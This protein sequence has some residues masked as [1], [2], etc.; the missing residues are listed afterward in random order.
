MSLDIVLCNNLKQ[1]QSQYELSEC[2]SI[3]CHLETEKETRISFSLHHIHVWYIM[4]AMNMIFSVKLEILL[5]FYWRFINMQHLL[6]WSIYSTDF[7]STTISIFLLIIKDLIFT[8]YIFPSWNNWQ[9][10]ICYV[11]TF[12]I[13]MRFLYF[14]PRAPLPPPLLLDPPSVSA[15]VHP[16]SVLHYQNQKARNAK[17]YSLK[18]L[19][20]TVSAISVYF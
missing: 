10:L 18:D 9:I 11:I 20:F 19:L 2:P 4:L 16:P 13:S 7:N 6:I 3:L 1:T 14:P 17:R 15:P 5:I 12:H 8:F